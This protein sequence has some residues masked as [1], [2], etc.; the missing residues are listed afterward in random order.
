ME[1]LKKRINNYDDVLE[2][3]GR[4]FVNKLDPAGAGK[5]WLHEPDMR[6]GGLP[7]DVLGIG[8]SRENSIIGG[9]AIRLAEDI[10]AMPEHVDK[11]RYKLVFS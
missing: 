3:E 9:N 6:V 4:S 11:F 10:L 8:H 2:Q 1:G 7:S 5:V